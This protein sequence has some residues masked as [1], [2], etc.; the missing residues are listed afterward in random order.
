MREKEKKKMHKYLIN[1]INEDLKVLYV[2]ILKLKKHVSNILSKHSKS[3]YLF[4]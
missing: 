2:L 4:H 3:T 1:T